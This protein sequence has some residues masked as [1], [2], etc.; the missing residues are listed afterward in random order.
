MNR[1]FYDQALVVS[2]LTT[3]KSIIVTKYFFGW[4]SDFYNESLTNLFMI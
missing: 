1:R 3:N 2:Y 4:Y